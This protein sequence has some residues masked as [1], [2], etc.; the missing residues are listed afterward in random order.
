MTSLHLLYLPFHSRNLVAF[1]RRHRADGG[2]RGYM[3]HSAL[4]A[5]FA[6]QAPK[7]FAV[8]GEAVGRLSVYAYARRSLTDLREASD[9]L[10]LPDV[11]ALVDWTAA[12]DKPMPRLGEGTRLRFSVRA[13]P[14]VR[15]GRMPAGG[16]A[17]GAETDAYLAAL[18]RW[19]AEGAEVEKKPVRSAVYVGWLRA[20]MDRHGG[21]ALESLSLNGFRLDSTL[22]KTGSREMPDRGVVSQRRPVA[23]FEG[24]LRVMEAD[25][26][27]DLLARGI[28]RHRAFGF[29][30]LLLRRAE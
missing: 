20:A 16:K 18:D 17:P 15:L 19:S 6:D 2:D 29:G 12:A 14:T 27:T 13:C 8:V 10:S 26:F 25:A 11:D 9:P 7:P 28:G 24:V 5:V 1:A 21:T 3:V 22:R 23:D 30:M 4:T